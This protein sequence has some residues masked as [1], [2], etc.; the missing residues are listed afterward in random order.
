MTKESDNQLYRGALKAIEAF[1]LGVSVRLPEVYSDVERI[2]TALSENKKLPNS[3]QFS[4]NV[5]KAISS[6]VEAAVECGKAMRCFEGSKTLGNAEKLLHT[7][8][9][10]CRLVQDCIQGLSSDTMDTPRIEEA[11]TR[12]AHVGQGAHLAHVLLVEVTELAMASNAYYLG[13][14]Q[15]V[16][17]PAPK[18]LADDMTMYC[19]LITSEYG[20]ANERG[21]KFDLSWPRFE[22]P[23]GEI[24]VGLLQSP[25]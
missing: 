21:S 14:R 4:T 10:N 22:L 12:L 13:G 3:N 20:K 9:L 15:L 1:L 11:G 25:E 8:L 17:P 19:A 5:S 16:V 6:H 24:N 7:I 18:G 2:R 23:G